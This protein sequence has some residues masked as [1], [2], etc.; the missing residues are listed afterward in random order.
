M[1][2][3]NPLTGGNIAAGYNPPQTKD[4]FQ[5]MLQVYQAR[6]MANQAKLFEQQFGSNVAAGKAMA[7][8]LEISRT[9]DG[10]IDQDA[11]R[12]NFAS[13]MAQDSPDQSF[14][15]PAQ[16]GQMTSNLL[17]ATQQQSAQQGLSTDR[18]DALVKAFSSLAADPRIESAESIAQELVRS[19]VTDFKT[20]RAVMDSLWNETQGDPAAIQNWAKNRIFS[21]QTPDQQSNMLFPGMTQ[22]DAGGAVA[23]GQFNP[24]AGTYA[25]VGSITKGTDPATATTQLNEQVPYANPAAGQP[26]HVA[27]VPVGAQVI[28]KKGNA[29]GV[30]LLPSGATTGPRVVKPAPVGG[31]TGSGGGPVIGPR[32]GGIGGNPMPVSG[33]N[34]GGV[35]APTAGAAIPLPGQ[36]PPMGAPQNGGS[37]AMPAAPVSQAPAPIPSQPQAPSGVIAGPQ[38]GTKEFIENDA[39][40]FQKQAAQESEALAA[41][42]ATMRTIEGQRKLLETFDAGPGTSGYLWIADLLRALPGDP[43]PD[44]VDKILQGPKDKAPA[45][46]GLQAYMK[47]NLSY[48]LS[49][50]KSKIGD[51]GRLSQFIEQAGVKA[52]PS[53]LMDQKAIEEIFNSVVREYS[54]L[55]QKNERRKE[56]ALAA[57]DGKKPFSA[58]EFEREWQQYV[59]SVVQPKQTGGI[60]GPK[61]TTP[62]GEAG[63]EEIHYVVRDGKLVPRGN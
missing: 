40:T 31:P 33:P 57:R 1:S 52:S 9:P 27:G 6:A 63:P 54:L 26:G 46:A 34:S 15:L 45:L 59:D 49:E 42:Q 35:V 18:R 62:Q 55:G 39:T 5:L 30:S 44:L 24:L 28:G 11:L 12:N 17:T 4:P 47:N 61:A 36:N 14:N 23:L 41:L 2:Q 3:N 50:L 60:T 51:D 20:A 16:L 19:N 53:E 25:P 43:F 38:P 8:A 56:W 21:L 32:G 13:I 29:L 37:P 7:K 22:T 10:G 58:L 48:T